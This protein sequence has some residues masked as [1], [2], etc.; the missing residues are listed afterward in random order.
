MS[1]NLLVQLNHVPLGWLL[2]E[3]ATDQYS[4]G[5]DQSWLATVGYSIS[6]HLP[7]EA[8][9]SEALKRFLANLLPEGR[10]L[11]ELSLT[12]QISKANIVG[13]ISAIGSE[14]TGALTFQNS[15]QPT[16]QLQTGFREISRD[17]LTV[18]VRYIFQNRWLRFR[19]AT[20]KAPDH[21]GSVP[22]LTVRLLLPAPQKAAMT[23]AA[24]TL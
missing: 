20:G 23:S 22:R 2:F 13:L 7:P 21:W 24:W 6:P 18:P 1:E 12:Q 5:Y 14:T 8:V 3:G 10:W 15:S 17:E 16:E 4:L 9:P 11:D 19:P